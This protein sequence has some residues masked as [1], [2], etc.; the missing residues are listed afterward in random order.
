MASV[1]KNLAYQSVYQIVSIVAPLITSP[2]IA[3]VL[4]VEKIGIYSYTYAIAY[5][6][7]LI[8]LLGIGNYGNREIAG[9]KDDKDKLK[10][11]FSELFVVHLTV[12][13]FCVM[14]YYGYCFLFVKEDFF[15]ALIQ[16]VWVVSAFFDISWL[17]FGLEKFKLTVIRSTTIKILI[18]VS[19]FVFVHSQAD[20]WKY[21]LVMAGGTLISQ[22][23]LWPFV[24]NYFEPKRVSVN[25]ALQHIKPLCILFL[26]Y[27]A[28]SI[29]RYMDKIMLEFMAS[30]THV[31]LYEN[32]ERAINI[33]TS[34]INAFGV[35]M[36]P[37]MSNLAARGDKKGTSHY[38]SISMEFVMCLTIAMAFGMAA[39][40]NTFSV[41]FWGD[42]FSQCG[43]LIQI[44]CPSLIFVA[45]ASILRNQFLVP[46]KM[47]VAMEVSISTGAVVNLIFNA[48]LIGRLQ[49]IG[50]AI[51][52]LAAE[53]SVCVVQMIITSR[54]LPLGEYIR[55][56]IPFVIFSIIMF[57]CVDTVG[58]LMDGNFMRLVVQIFAGA[59]VYCICVLAYFE[60]IK[61][62]YYLLIKKQ[63]LG[64]I[65]KK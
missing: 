60:F 27:I 8:A 19:V 46:Q 64:K 23:A 37:K 44:L 59:A 21:C 32:A 29:Y 31:G 9:V 28:A 34:I 54:K 26:P 22:L 36:L 25:G 50:A 40:A 51:G 16:G 1:K 2:Y 43:I 10:T 5:Y 53:L 42:E 56:S 11:T 65:H 61:N 41:V 4:G 33:P 52:T 47:D 57:V 48:L 55:K 35:V 6:F 39:V 45:F 17:F 30:K 18:T 20:L 38:I 15:C 49:A 14:A 24:G 58:N 63:V 62:S 13:G 3:R 12:A 7:S